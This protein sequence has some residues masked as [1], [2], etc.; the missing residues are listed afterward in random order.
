MNR[1]NAM[2]A[3]FAH[4]AHLGSLWATG[5]LLEWLLHRLIIRGAES[6]IFGAG[7]G[8]RALE[9]LLGVLYLEISV[10]LLGL[11]HLWRVRRERVEA[12]RREA[13]IGSEL[14]RE[15]RHGI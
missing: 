4:P 14:L 12:S 5:L 2:N 6:P 13:M 9:F 11:T 8:A 10:A 3:R 15:G 1:E 7:A